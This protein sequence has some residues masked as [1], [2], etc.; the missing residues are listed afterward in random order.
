MKFRVLAAVAAVSLASYATAVVAQSDVI[1]QREGLMKEWGQATRP[2]GAMLQGKAPFE[3]AP[4]QA[5]LDVYVK[6]AATLPTL[7][8]EGSQAGSDALPAVWEKNAEFK[9]L[10]TKFAADAKAARAA[11]TDE[12]SFKANFPAVVRSCGGCHDTFRA[13]S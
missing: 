3:L 2:V 10:F 13:K 5:A 7:F 4:V 12:A 1:K 8:P 9:A 6:N 11:I